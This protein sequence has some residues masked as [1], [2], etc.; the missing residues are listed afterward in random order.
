M[1]LVLDTNILLGGLMS[2]AGPP[3]RL[4][5]TWQRGAFTLI[6]CE[7]QLEELRDVSRR[8][9]IR[10]RIQTTEVGRMV[11]TLRALALMVEKLPFVDASPDPYDN[12]LLSLSMAG[13]ADLLVTGDKRDLLGLKRHA[14]TAI[15]TAR[16][17]IAR[18]ST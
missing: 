1:R 5:A 11:N 6:S 13:K 16:Q 14:G 12:Y 7:A 4:Y 15:V 17:A 9:H 8:E 10:A 3:A 2:S 18:I